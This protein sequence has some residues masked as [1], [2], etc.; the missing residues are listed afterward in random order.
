MDGEKVNKRLIDSVRHD[1]NIKGV[2]NA[3][4]TDKGE[5]KKKTCCADSKY[6]RIRVYENDDGYSYR[7]KNCTSTFGK[8][9]II[10]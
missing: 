10:I 1:I 6:K 9:Y 4:M 7:Q 5:W 8:T 2:N 3:K